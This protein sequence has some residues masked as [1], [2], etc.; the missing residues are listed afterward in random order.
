MTQYQIQVILELFLSKVASS[1][2]SSR[3]VQQSVRLET[4]DRPLHPLNFF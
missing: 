2:I 4:V 1:A 3:K